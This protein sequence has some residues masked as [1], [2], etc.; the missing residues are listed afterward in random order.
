MLFGGASV[1]L[2]TTITKS[3][4]HESGDG[5]LAESILLPL[6][7]EVSASIGKWNMIT[8][9]IYIAIAVGLAI[10]Y[11]TLKKK[12][13][14]AGDTEK[15]EPEHPAPVEEKPQQPASTTKVQ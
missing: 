7:R 1:L 2:A 11:I 4:I 15:K 14:E 6:I 13:P 10:L 9:G 8:G 12:N 3:V 5:G